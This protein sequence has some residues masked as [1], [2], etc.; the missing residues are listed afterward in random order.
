V[1]QQIIWLDCCFSGEL[2]NFRET[3]LARQGSE[4]DRDFI[5]LDILHKSGG[6]AVPV[7][8]EELLAA[9]K[10]I[11]TAEGIFTAPEGGACLP[12]LKQLIVRGEVSRDEKIVSFNTGSGLK[13]LDAFQ[14]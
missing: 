10:E 13:Y 6:T 12:A 4:G 3:D 5:M 7:T 1:R 9:V 14:D 2:L 8:D 11:A